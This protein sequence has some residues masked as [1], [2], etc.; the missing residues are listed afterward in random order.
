MDCESV[1]QIGLDAAV[2]AVS[3][4]YAKHDRNRSLWDIWSHAMHHA[5]AV[6]EEIRKRSLLETNG[7]KLRQE[8]ADLAL[9]LFTMLAR[10]NGPLGS[11]KHENEAP[12]DL[13]VRISVSLS[14]LLWNRYPGVCPWC[15]CATNP[16][17]SL[18]IDDH[19]FGQPCCCDSLR[20]AGR[21]KEKEELRAR[22]KRT[23]WLAREHAIRRPKSIDDWQEMI[24]TIYRE[25][26]R[27]ATLSEV[28]LH[29]LE[30]MGET[31]DGLIRMYTYSSK[32]SIED[33]FP[34]RQVRLEDELADV[35]SWLFGLVERLD[36]EIRNLSQEGRSFSSPT[37]STGRLLLSQILGARYGGDEGRVLRCIHCKLAPCRCEVRLL[38]SEEDVEDLLAKLADPSKADTE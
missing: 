21:Q 25:R 9:W 35:L 30:E 11:P 36:L 18:R 22:A 19:D 8:I 5:A 12:Q 28:A 2:D 20:I 24:G 3:V 23:R 31:S 27:Q 15:Y 14:D 10:L 16:D 17:A 33:E 37:F 1:G 38:Q 4:I 32:D 7:E 34:L 29:L 26:L 6:A 13:V